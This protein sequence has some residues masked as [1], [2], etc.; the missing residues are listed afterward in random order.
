MN[1]RPSA[2]DSHSGCRPRRGLVISP[3]QN[4]TLSQ[5]PVSEAGSAGGVLQ[6]GQRIGSAVG[7]AAIGAVFFNRLAASGGDYAVA[8][9]MG[10]YVTIAFMAIALAAAITDVVA[11]RREARASPGS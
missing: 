1:P 6:T 2:Q 9:R 3:N 5:V 7:I 11:G 8:F 10:L 4:L